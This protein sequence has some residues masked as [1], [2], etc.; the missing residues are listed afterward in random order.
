[1][2]EV[3]V[4]PMTGFD[5]CGAFGVPGDAIGIAGAFRENLELTSAGMDS[6]HGASEVVSRAILGNDVALVEHAVQPVKPAIRTPGQ[7]T[8]Q[9]V[10]IR[11]TEAGEHHLATHFLAVLLAQEKQIW[12]IE[13]QTPPYPTATPV[14]MFSPPANTVTVSARP[15]TSV[16][17]RIFTR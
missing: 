9:L 17:S 3:I 12:R 15:S 2:K 4:R 16:S 14:G 5:D 11:A 13:H 7:R 1:M 6:P 8:G 10:R